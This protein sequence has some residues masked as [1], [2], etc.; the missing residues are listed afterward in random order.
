MYFY[1][2]YMTFLE[3]HIG[4]YVVG[5]FYVMDI[6]SEIRNHWIFYIKFTGTLLLKMAFLIFMLCH[7][8]RH[9]INDIRITTLDI[10]ACS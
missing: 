5:P 7:I 6:I 9:G 1:D 3:T 2:N 4:T 10:G 8:Q